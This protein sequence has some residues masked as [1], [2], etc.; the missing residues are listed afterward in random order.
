MFV[1]IENYYHDVLPLI[2]NIDCISTINPIL[3]FS[4]NQTVCNG[5]MLVLVDNRTF[6]LNDKQYR[7]LC[8]ILTK[9]L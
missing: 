7:E 8:E 4:N 3:E 2:I 9:R 6:T 5:Y 1:K